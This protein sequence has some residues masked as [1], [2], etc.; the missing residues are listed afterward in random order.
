MGFKIKEIT[1]KATFFLLQL[2]FVFVGSS[3]AIAKDF[4]PKEIYTSTSMV[5]LTVLH[6]LRGQ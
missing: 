5:S 3:T 4:D 2:I 6:P 1:L